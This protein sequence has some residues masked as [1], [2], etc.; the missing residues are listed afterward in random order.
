MRYVT[1]SEFLK[2]VAH[3]ELVAL[4]ES[5]NNEVDFEIIEQINADAC[6]EVD[7]YLRGIYT[8]PIEEPIDR[9]ITAI[10]VSIMKFMLYKR[11]DER[12]VP[13]KIVELYKLTVSKLKDIQSR[14]FIL[15]APGAK[16]GEPISGTTVQSWTP[17]PIFSNHF[18]KLFR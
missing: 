8:L 9:N 12:T 11:R 3:G 6:A 14:K 5:K 13:D 18:T 4:T 10:T 16:D 7:G 17:E 2:I 1:E 15:D